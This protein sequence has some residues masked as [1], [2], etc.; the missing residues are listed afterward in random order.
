VVAAKS[1]ALTVQLGSAIVQSVVEAIDAIPLGEGSREID[2]IRR[3][4]VRAAARDRILVKERVHDLTK[5]FSRVIISSP[6]LGDFRVLCGDR[7]DRSADRRCSVYF[8]DGVDN[9]EMIL[10]SFERS[11]AVV[12]T[13]SWSGGAVTI[14]DDSV[15]LGGSSFALRPH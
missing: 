6:I 13:F 4:F 3:L 2:D 14:S 5:G 15:T 9:R 11:G 8:N 1:D 7:P 12:H 10:E